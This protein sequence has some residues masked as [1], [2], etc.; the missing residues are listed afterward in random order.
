MKVLSVEQY[1]CRTHYRKELLPTMGNQVTSAGKSLN[2]WKR[3]VTPDRS[4]AQHGRGGTVGG[5]R[6]C[7]ADTKVSKQGDVGRNETMVGS[8]KVV[9]GHN[10]INSLFMMSRI[11]TYI[12]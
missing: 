4:P 3:D 1:P 8:G 6:N 11:C 2:L 7:A 5:G 10:I 12:S 9:V